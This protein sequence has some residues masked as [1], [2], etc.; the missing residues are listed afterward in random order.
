MDKPL[1]CPPPPTGEQNQKKRTFDVL[2]K[3]DNSIRCRQPLRGNLVPDAHVAAILF[4]HGVGTLYTHD[5][6]F[7]R[8]DSLEVRDPFS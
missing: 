4:Q 8:F 6:D 7:R 2:P 5:R 3:P 1:A